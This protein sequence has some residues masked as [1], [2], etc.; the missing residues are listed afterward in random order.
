MHAPLFIA[1]S[2]FS[3]IGSP[4]I[5]R[6]VLNLSHDFKGNLPDDFNRFVPLEELMELIYCKIY[7]LNTFFHNLKLRFRYM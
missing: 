3:S 6:L 4:N 7:I 2:F 5:M 1:I